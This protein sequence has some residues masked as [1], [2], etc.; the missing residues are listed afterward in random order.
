[1]EIIHLSDLHYGSAEFKEKC[2]ENII[3]YI[4]GYK[5]KI[6]LVIITGDITD[7]GRYEEYE[8]IKRYIDRIPTEKLI[9]PGNHDISKNGAGKINYETFFGSTTTNNISKK[10]NCLA[11]GICSAKDGIAISEIGDQ[12]L[13]Y[14]AEQYLNNSEKRKILA[15]HHHL[16][17]V[18]YSSK[19][20][21]IPIDAG[22]VLEILRMFEIELVLMG[23][24]HV[25]HVWTLNGTTFLY[26][27]TSTSGKVRANE[28]PCFNHIYM[29][30]FE[31]EV[32]IV[33]SYS[34][35]KQPLLRRTPKDVNFI[36]YRKARIEY[37][38]HAKILG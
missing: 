27:G 17:A 3:E 8:G 34:L 31:L 38:L 26:C 6:D 5:S 32:D 20:L 4:A 22:E 23:H 19:S 15:L 29:D 13:R 14:I 10:S 2:F 12:Q 16:I 9:V 35:N 18:P 30:D 21:N 7:H 11:L 28:P 37:L 24:R 25:P 36:K 1:M 33:D